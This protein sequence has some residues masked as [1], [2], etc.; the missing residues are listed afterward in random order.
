MP[1][2]LGQGE[3]EVGGAACAFAQNATTTI[4]VER[5]GKRV[6]VRADGG[7]P[8]VCPTE[9]DA[10]ARVTIGVRGAGGTGVSVA[11]NLRI[12]RR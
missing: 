12:S 4:R 2:R 9:L 7:E 6:S 5:A 8:R 1:G 3:L 11:H 10:T